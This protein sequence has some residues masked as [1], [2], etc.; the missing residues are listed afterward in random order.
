MPDMARKIH[1]AIQ[2]VAYRN[3]VIP[4]PDDDDGR[5]LDELEAGQP[6]NP[7][8]V[9]FA[10]I[11]DEQVAE[12]KSVSAAPGHECGPAMRHLHALLQGHGR[13][14]R[15]QA[16]GHWCA[17]LLAGQ[18]LRHL[19]RTRPG[20]AG[21]FLLRL[22]AHEGAGPGMEAGKSRKIVL[23]STAGQDHRLCRSRHRPPI[24]ANR[25]YERLFA[26]SA[27]AALAG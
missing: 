6:I 1:E 9:L 7:P 3:G 11:T 13:H 27:G 14:G 5:G 17:A 19:C 12:W 25:L 4:W 26:L 20:N 21:S 15:G 8:E 24:G 23:V 10:K 2:P 18:G 16:S 22:A